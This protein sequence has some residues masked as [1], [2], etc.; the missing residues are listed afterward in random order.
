MRARCQNPNNASYYKYGERGI[1]VC[2]RWDDSTNFLAD[3][4][5]APPGM[6]LDRIDPDGNYEPKNCRWVTQWQQL[7]NRRFIRDSDHADTPE[8]FRRA[9]ELDQACAKAMVEIRELAGPHAAIFLQLWMSQLE[10]PDIEPEQKAKLQDSVRRW[11][12]LDSELA[13][14]QLEFPQLQSLVAEAITRL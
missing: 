7:I 13:A 12:E 1:T 8:P 5:E 11:M 14:L 3:M 4:G 6:S 9:W 2:E 10:T